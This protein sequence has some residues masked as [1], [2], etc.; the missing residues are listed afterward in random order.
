MKIY[1][2]I[3]LLFAA[4]IL[5]SC[6][7]QK[8][9]IGEAEAAEI[10]VGV[11]ISGRIEKI[12]VREGDIVLKGDVLGTLESQDL[13]AKLQIVQAALKEANDQFNFAKKTYDRLKNMYKKQVI[14][15]QQFDEITYKYQAARQKVAAV[16]GEYNAVM[17]FYKEIS[18]I[19]PI[20]GE[21]TQIISNAGEIVSA[22][23]PIFTMTNP[24]DVWTVFNIRE[25]DMKNIIKGDTY[26]V[27]FPALNRTV[28]MSVSYIAAL[29]TFANWKPT[30]QTGN[31]DLK[32]FEVRLR[33]NEKIPNLRPGMTAVLK[34]KE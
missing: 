5:F 14:S 13:D 32:T 17:S 22:G 12:S 8:E 33:S 24:D 3:F 9:I 29:G 23:Y 21:I 31:Y 4:A 34:I 11:K 25:D 28:N 15:K 26:K 30:A 2:L 19:A 10:D 18:I 7:R 6:S 27:F 16:T 20:D 1:K